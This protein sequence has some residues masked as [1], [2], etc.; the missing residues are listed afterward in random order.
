LLRTCFE[1]GIDI[2]AEGVETEREYRWLMDEGIELYQ[3]YLF[4]KPAFEKL[5]TEFY[6]PTL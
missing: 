2:I 6:L 1:L 5:S 3:G 4:A